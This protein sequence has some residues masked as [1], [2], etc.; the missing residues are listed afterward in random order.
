MENRELAL[1]A[2][3]V[4]DNKK[5]KDIII[6]DISEKASF[7]D[8]FVI[9]SGNSERQVAALSEDVQDSFQ[10]DGIEAK[11]IEGQRGSGWILM[12]YGDLIVNILTTDM[13][14]RYNIEKAWGDGEF[15]ALEGSEN[16]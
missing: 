10:V 7:A 11:N 4:L 13:R 14:D 9:A 16:E 1:K 12:D 15:I 6:I 2:A 3:R 8:Y 5:A